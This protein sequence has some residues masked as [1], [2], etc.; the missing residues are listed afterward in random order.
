LCAG[1]CSGSFNGKILPGGGMIASVILAAG[2]SQRMGT[3]KALLRTGAT[4]FVQQIVAAHR[5]AHVSPIV[6]VVGAAADEIARELSG[7]SAKVV[8]ND[9]HH[10]GQ[11]SS[12]HAGLRAISSAPVDG[13]LIHPVDHPGV[14]VETLTLLMKTFEQRHPDIVLPVF[15][16]ARGHPVVFASG[17][18]AELLA[19]PLD[20]GA[21]ALVRAHAGSTVEVV[22]VD[23]GVVLDIDTPA[24]YERFQT[25]L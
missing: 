10:L 13:V 5:E 24:E 3:P 12:I 20:L 18:F 11:L 15:R 17:L 2:D 25:R 14:R 8:R 1:S 6:V 7:T 23:E 21:R 16:G 9:H 4:T 22:T 19:T